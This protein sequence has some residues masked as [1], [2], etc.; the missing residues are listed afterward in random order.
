[1]SNNEDD[2]NLF[3]VQD[4]SYQSLF[5]PI[6]VTCKH[7]NTLNDERSEEK[8]QPQRPY[9]FFIIENINIIAFN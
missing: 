1:M 6:H 7:I 9:L 4:S 2:K 5:T 3:K 8:L